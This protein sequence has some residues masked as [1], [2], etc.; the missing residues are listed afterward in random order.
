[1]ASSKQS[2]LIT[3]C[4]KGSAGH[5]LAL[6]FA[7][8]GMRVFATARSLGSLAGLEDK[9]IETLMLDVTS[10]DSIAAL[11]VDVAAR[12]GGKL[13]MLFNNAGMMYE[14][15]GIETDISRVRQM[16]ETNVFGLFNMVQAFTPLLLAAVSDSS[17]PPVV[18]NT[19]SVLAVVPYP[20]SS[21]YNA[22]K[23]AVA[24]Y[25]DALRVELAPLGIKVVTLYM[26]VVSTGLS[27]PGDIKFDEDSIY[28]AAEAGVKK[29]SKDHQAGG[30]KPDLF[31][32]QV[33]NEVLKKR[34][35]AQGEYVWKGTNAF[36][37]WLLNAV[38]GRKSFD[39]SNAKEI[40]FDEKVK[41]AIS[42]RGHAFVQKR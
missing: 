38:G 22:S 29:R 39:G 1:M 36:L 27:S 12:T 11:K 2:V 9:G 14:A 32:K 28:A 16:F 23:A 4:S 24:S 34:G 25:S 33:I 5:A 37:V 3:G 13:D 31:A 41:Q 10:A 35:I 6:E 19:A 26:G 7:S 15:P 18:I 40:S 21:A 17:R 42:E 8:R 20:F 30:M